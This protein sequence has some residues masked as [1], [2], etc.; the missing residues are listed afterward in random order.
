MLDS[1]RCAIVL[2]PALTS[3]GMDNLVLNFFRVN[4]FNIIGRA[5]VSMTPDQ[6][7]LMQIF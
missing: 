4:G 7:R 1:Q 3:S 6:V 5:C 2:R